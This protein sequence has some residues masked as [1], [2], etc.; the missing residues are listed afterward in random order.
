MQI[1]FSSQ[2]LLL[3]LV[4]QPILPSK[5]IF[6]LPD[7]CSCF[8][9]L[10]TSSLSQC[11]SSNSTSSALRRFW[12]LFHCYSPAVS[13]TCVNLS[14]GLFFLRELERAQHG[15]VPKWRADHRVRTKTCSAIVQYLG[16][17]VLP[18]CHGGW[19]YF[20]GIGDLCLCCKSQVR[21]V[22]LG[23]YCMLLGITR[24]SWISS[25]SHFTW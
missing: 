19:K 21:P 12:I 9:H 20:C 5:N 6:P 10:Q 4:F 17:W 7:F 23:V 14:P 2:A 16:P 15:G 18:P 22:H 24:I 13:S 8:S 11:P 25:L 1:T 3:F